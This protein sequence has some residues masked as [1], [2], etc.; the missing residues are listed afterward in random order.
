MSLSLLVAKKFFFK[1]LFYFNDWLML[2]TTKISLCR[3]VREVMKGKLYFLII[4]FNCFLCNFKN[5]FEFIIYFSHIFL[6]TF[7]SF[8]SMASF[9]LL[10]YVVPM[11]EIGCKNSLVFVVVVVVLGFLFV[12]CCLFVFKHIP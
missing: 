4:L 7:F 8:K 12:V 3:H 2:H 1:G 5:V 11:A 6:L 9:S 10:L